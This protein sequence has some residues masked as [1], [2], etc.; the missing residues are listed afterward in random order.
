MLDSPEL[1]DFDIMEELGS[2]NRATVYLVNCKRGRL[3]NRQLALRKVVSPN[4]SEITRLSDSSA[5]HLSLSHPS[6][7]SLFSTFSTPSAHF[8]LLELALGGSLSSHISGETLSENHL[9]YIVKG[10]ADALLYLKNEGVVH[11]D[12]RPS[13]I[14]LATDGRPK[15]SGFELATASPPSKISLDYF[16]EEAHHYVSPFAP[17]LH[18]INPLSN[19]RSEIIAGRLHSFEADW[20]SLGCVVFAALSGRP[21]FRAASVDDTNARILRGYCEIPT[22][23]SIEARQLLSGLLEPNPKWRTPP[24]EILALPFFDGTAIPLTLTSPNTPEDLRSKHALFES[25]SK[26]SSSTIT[27]PRLRLNRHPYAPNLTHV[28]DFRNTQKRAALRDELLTRRIVSD[29]LPSKYQRLRHHS[30]LS[31]TSPK[32][33]SQ[34][35]EANRPVTSPYKTNL[36]NVC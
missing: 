36:S 5:L 9:R 2:G 13:N 1:G 29:P 15:L 35:E 11:R 32:T 16:V 20:W 14:L 23:I 3:R 6:I 10:I 33:H 30:L 24:S 28:D 7:L 26:P 18:R 21:P 12:I 19:H 34:D 22:G 31:R 4:S 27:P 25:R 17:P 8:Q